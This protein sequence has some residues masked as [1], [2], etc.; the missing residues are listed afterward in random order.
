MSI[1]RFQIR[2]VGCNQ[3]FLR[4]DAFFRCMQIGFRGIA[5]RYGSVLVLTGRNSLIH[6][7]LGAVG[8]DLCKLQTRTLARTV[9]CS[10]A[11][12][13]LDWAR[14]AWACAIC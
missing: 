14:V 8:S 4:P 11:S 6:Q 12:D 5:G 13:A 9:A 1:I 2:L 3:T 7:R 10:C